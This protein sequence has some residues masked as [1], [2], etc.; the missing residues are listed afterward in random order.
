MSANVLDQFVSMKALLLGTVS[1][2][3]MAITTIPPASIVGAMLWT[4][5]LGDVVVA[6]LCIF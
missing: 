1:V 3:C 5:Y 2:G 6:H 4:G